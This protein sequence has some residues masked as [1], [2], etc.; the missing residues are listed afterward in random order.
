LA[1][2]FISYSRKDVGF[3]RALAASLEERGKDVWVDLDDIAPTAEWEAEIHAGIEGALAVVVVLSP[4]FLASPVCAR[5]LAHAQAS[6]KRLLPLVRRAVE[7]PSVPPSLGSLNWIFCREGDDDNDAF[8]T[9]LE[10]L[11]TDLDWVRAHTRLLVRAVEWDAGGRDRS[12]LLRG[13]DLADAERRLP[14]AGK[15]PAPTALQAEYVFASRRAAGARQRAVLGGVLLALAVA[16]SLAVVA[17]LQRNHA[18]EQA[19]V[20]QSR[21]LAASAAAQ[22]GVDPQLALLLAV[23]AVGRKRTPEAVRVLR[24]S[25]VASKVREE[26]AAGRPLQR[27]EFSPDG[28]AVL[29]TPYR[30]NSLLWRPGSPCPVALRGAGPVDLAFAGSAGRLVSDDFDSLTTWRRRGAVLVRG[31][32]FHSPGGLEVSP[33]GE[34]VLTS[35]A[36]GRRAT[37]RSTR[38]GT[39]LAT[40]RGEPLWAGSGG[41]VAVR[42]PGRAAVRFVSVRG[43]ARAV[44]RRLPP[45]AYVDVSDI[46]PSGGRILVTTDAG[47]R[48]LDVAAGTWTQRLRGVEGTSPYPPLVAFSPDDRRLVVAARFVPQESGGP[49]TRT[50]DWSVRLFD[51]RTGRLVS[52][53]R[54]HSS[55]VASAVFSPDSR[56]LATGGKDATIRLWNARTGKLAGVLLGHGGEVTS[57]E[58]SSDGRRILSASSD[59]TARIW[60]P[61]LPLPPVL[62][63]ETAALADDGV[64]AAA[65]TPD[66]RV[67]VVRLAGNGAAR[68]TRVPHD[69]GDHLAIGSDGRL[70]IGGRR[71]LD[72]R[73]GRA[74]VRLPATAF[75]SPSPDA[76]LAVT[77]AGGLWSVR[78][79]VRLHRLGARTE[80]A[81]FADGD[82]LLA[83]TAG[84]PQT[85]GGDDAVVLWDARTGRRLRTLHGRGSFVLVVALSPD[86]ARLATGEFDGTVRLWDTSTGRRLDLGKHD[87]QV[88]VAGF[89]PDGSLLATGSKDTKARV[90]DAL[91]G[92]PVAVLSGHANSVQSVAFSA[93][94]A[95]LLTGGAD[96]SA[97]LWD[98][99]TGQELEKLD[100]HSGQAAVER[101]RFVGSAPFVAVERDDGTVT[102]TP[103]DACGPVPRLLALA[104]GR[105]PR[106]LTPAERRRYLHESSGTAAP[107]C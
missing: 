16:V 92:D 88:V 32:V 97:I 90:W 105:T 26:V 75:L 38:M 39:K 30:G 28:A 36:R 22:L 79:G 89:S 72:V 9:L 104:A 103:C 50:G 4:D 81:A 70:V 24:D 73:G 80:S 87:E 86:G 99:Q 46:S 7:A 96:G 35:D 47:A 19:H 48:V 21:E 59:G 65:V 5:E 44:V 52:T 45:G 61:D 63:G 34:I 54:G 67:S 98:A 11:D 40:V 53:L 56:Y 55:E 106:A 93:D 101:A 13:R 107:A 84:S 12:L 83:T 69:F 85:A 68:T 64:F 60:E 91:T 76:R 25:L 43:P 8:A 78:R 23:D 82:R 94:D 42:T 2:V 27:A 10:A 18:V 6:G 62:R 100:P 37:A 41:R 20:A 57:V 1:D 29:L 14:Q 33:D 71:V 74:S 49:P 31:R 95:L 51:A 102:V 3:V 15:E 66:G 58:F 17:L 77:Y